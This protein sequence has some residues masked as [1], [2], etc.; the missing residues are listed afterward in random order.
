MTHLPVPVPDHA[1]AAAHD[2]DRERARRLRRALDESGRAGHPAGVPLA[3]ILAPDP[4]EALRLQIAA[5]AFEAAVRLALGARH[6]PPIRDDN[7]VTLPE[8][9]L[10]RHETLPWDPPEKRGVCHLHVD[11]RAAM[12]DGVADLDTGRLPLPDALPGAA[13]LTAMRDATANRAVFLKGLL[14]DT[15]R[16]DALDP[17]ATGANFLAQAI[18]GHIDLEEALRQLRERRL[19]GRGASTDA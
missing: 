1:L 3:A 16:D 7:R 5:T 14:G 11:W 8:A 9:L 19:A 12:R 2:A 18:P 17:V 15:A 6:G 13:L 4:T 10:T